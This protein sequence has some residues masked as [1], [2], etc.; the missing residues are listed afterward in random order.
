[1]AEQGRVCV[2]V[3]SGVRGVRGDVRIRPF[4]ELPENLTA[5]GALQFEDGTLADVTVKGTAK[6][7]V[8]AVFAGVCDRSAAETLK[9]TKLYIDRASLPD[10]GDE[11]FYYH[12][13]I[14]LAVETAEGERIGEVIAV[15][16]YGAGDLI[17]VKL[18]GRRSPVLIPFTQDCVPVVNV[19]DGFVR[20]TP[21]PG[22]LD[23]DDAAP[24]EDESVQD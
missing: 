17:D 13:L 4:T 10:P 7:E 23:D 12:Q 8:L 14:G 21:P 16:E 1:M 24:N 22:L 2:G 3:V 20:V 15:Q 11:E 19:K 18:S 9:G 5:Y 6:G